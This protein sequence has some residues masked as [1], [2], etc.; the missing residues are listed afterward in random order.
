MTGGFALVTWFNTGEFVI[1][2]GGYHPSFNVPDYY[3]VVPRLGFNWKPSNTLTV[4][5]GVYFTLCSRAVMLGGRLDAS[6]EKGKIRAAFVA[7][8][9]AL[10]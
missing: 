5:G 8:M 3:P 10:V 1:S 6:F 2:L 7:G 9:D 4:K